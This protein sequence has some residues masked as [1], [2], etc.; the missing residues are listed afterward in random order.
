[1]HAMGVV[2]IVLMAGTAAWVI[3]ST[4]APAFPQMLAALRGDPVPPQASVEP[5]STASTPLRSVEAAAEP[6][7]SV[8]A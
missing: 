6:T 4:V 7:L 3:W 8:T 2:C 5:H 1:M